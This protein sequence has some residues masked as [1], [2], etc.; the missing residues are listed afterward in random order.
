MRTRAA[1]DTTVP[2][3]A[4][5]FES[6]RFVCLTYDQ[7]LSTSIHKTRSDALSCDMHPQDLVI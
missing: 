3:M 1:A 6:I 4:T 2:H 7:T 5:V